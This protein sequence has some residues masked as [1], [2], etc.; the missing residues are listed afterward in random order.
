MHW[1]QR[2]IRDLGISFLNICSII[3]FLHEYFIVN[4]FTIGLMLS[5]AWLLAWGFFI[6]LT[7]YY[8]GKNDQEND[9]NDERM[10]VSSLSID[11]PST[12]LEYNTRITR[13][14]KRKKPN[15]GFFL[16]VPILSAKYAALESSSGSNFVGI[17]T[18]IVNG[19]IKKKCPNCGCL[20]S[21]ESKFC[22]NCGTQM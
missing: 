16:T 15:P 9:I 4:K 8:N 17:S 21:Y 10:K 22:D 14:K 5:L 19:I 20:S 3:V 12:N 7:L 6:I 11:N 1:I 2:K 13:R 18:P